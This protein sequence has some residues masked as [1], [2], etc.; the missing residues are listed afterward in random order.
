MTGN[1]ILKDLK[2]STTLFEAIIEQSGEGITLT[3]TDGNYIFA[4]KSFGQLT[5]YSETELKGMNI[6]EL[7]PKGSNYSMFTGVSN[8]EAALREVE[9]I[10]KDGSLLRVEIKC[11]SIEL[12]N[13]V[14]ILCII[15]DITDRKRAEAEIKESEDKFR[16]IFDHSTIGKSITRTNG[17]MIANDAF[18][19]MLGYTREEYKNLRWQAVTHP[20]DLDLSRKVVDSILSGETDSARFAKRY[21]H[22]DGSVIW[23]DVSTVLM[24]DIK[25]KPLYLMTVAN[26]ITD[27]KII[28]IEREK[29]IQMLE[30]LNEVT[31]LQGLMKSLLIFMKELSGC[32]AVGIRLRDGDDFPYYVTRGFPND[33]VGAETHLCTRDLNGQL[34]RDACGNPQLECMCGNILCGRFDPGKPFF[35]EFGSFISNNTTALI[36]STTEK[37]RQAST[38]NR[39]NREGFE[40]V[41]LVPLRAGGVTFGLMQFNAYRIGC[42]SEKFIAQIER[43]ARSVAIALAQRKA[44]ESLRISEKKYRVLFDT[45]PLGITIADPSGNIVET[46]DTAVKMLGI[47]KE[48]HKSRRIESP[49]WRILDSGGTVMDPQDYTSTRALKENRVIENVEM[50]V[51]KPDGKT[52]WLSVTAAPLLLEKYGVVVTYSD[53]TTRKQAEENYQTLFREM[54][55]GF[56]LH[57]IIC[58]SA[59]KPVDYRFLAVN[60]AFERL[61]GLKA[62]QIIGKTVLEVLPGTEGHWIDTYGRVALTGEPIHFENKHGTLA[63]FY[64][65]KAYRPAKNQFACIFTDIT[66]RKRADELLKKSEERYRTILEAINDPVFISSADHIIQY[67][68]MAMKER[69]GFDAMGQKCYKILHNLDE[70]CSWCDSQKIFSEGYSEKNIT[71]P[72]DNRSFNIV[73]SVFVNENGSLSKLSVLRD[74]TEFK[75]LQEHLQQAQKIESIGT[76]AGGIAHDFNN[77][78]SPIMLHSELV[79][80]ELPKDSPLQHD[81]KEIFKASN[82]AKELV[83]Q[84]LTFARKKS[85]EKIFLK[86]SIVIKEAVKFLRSTIPTSIDI[87]YNVKTE[88]DT[89]NTDPTQLNQ[90]IMN[91]G[92]NASHAMREKGGLL[93]IILDNEDISK[94]KS[95]SFIKLYPGRYLKLSVRDTGTGIQPGVIDRIFDPYFTTKKVGEGTGLGLATVYG[96]VKDSGGE[97]KVE[98]EP[99]KGTVF[100]IYFPLV[101]EE[102]PVKEEQKAKLSGGHEHI[103]FVDD[104]V[105]SVDTME[106]MLKKL[107][108]RVTTK[109]SS[110]EALEFFSQ[111]HDAVDL[112][113]TDMTMPDMTGKELAEQIRTLNKNIPVILCTGYSDQINEYDAIEMG[114]NA[115]IMKPYVRMELANTIRKVLKPV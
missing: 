65:V 72:K 62:D 43:L 64:E 47:T 38:R 8:H 78:L 2:S 17:E 95:G 81:M 1:D 94:E 24:R 97:I 40:S 68:N 85:S 71:S 86:S 99:G 77:I 49:E 74:I 4:S 69:V 83:Q 7:L 92:V 91:L 102:T 39:C 37:D 10:K 48:E 67:M 53:I 26:D 103:L 31:D 16:Y 30:I 9:M 13:V 5:G 58:D 60:P 34:E 101:I 32:D 80:D 54:I 36:A 6:M 12:N 93:E 98:S 88:Q 18:Y 27:K 70:E 35:T 66:N 28:A 106:K 111:H 107:G 87:H 73:S 61:T 22:K 104:E 89:I 90:I 21:I 113:I 110:T 63:K 84:I 11:C 55:D 112:V 23:A 59:G 105:A 56:A 51:M 33:F 57:E 29:N 50:E 44:E 52:V 100:H 25:G 79:M 41:F 96:I 114:I 14:Y 108:Y 20:E 82:R 46:N 45:F 15:R 19:K 75:A 115:F 42:F 3:D 76:L 109:T